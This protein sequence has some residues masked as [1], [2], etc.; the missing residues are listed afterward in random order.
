[1]RDDVIELRQFECGGLL[2]VE[3]VKGEI[4]QAGARGDGAAASDVVRHRI[5]AMENGF[6]M[7]CGEDD[8]C[9]SR[10]A[11]EFAPGE[12]RVATGRG[13]TAD[14]RHQVQPFR[15]QLRGEAGDIGDVGDVADAACCRVALGAWMIHE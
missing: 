4:A 15:R 12:A 3:R 1:M 6:G 5:D 7:S 13:K 10:S 14:R 9:Y 2:E 8:R 11:A